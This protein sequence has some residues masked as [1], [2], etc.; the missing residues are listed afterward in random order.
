MVASGGEKWIFQKSGSIHD[1]YYL[2]YNFAL[3]ISYDKLLLQMLKT[4][5]ALTL[6]WLL[7]FVVSS[8]PNES[9]VARSN[10]LT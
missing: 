6:D 8:E 5:Y 4:F 7:M 9:P 2:L 3:G 10:V 1:K